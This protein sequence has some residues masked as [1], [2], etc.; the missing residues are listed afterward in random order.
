MKKVLLVIDMQNI[1]VGENHTPMFKYDNSTLIKNV[2]TVISQHDPKNVYYILNIMK[3]NLISKL[4]PF[5]AFEGSYEV[6]LVS[7]L[8][9]VNNNKFKKYKGN[10]FSNKELGQAL[11][12][13]NVMEIEIVGVDG[14][15]CVARTAFGALKEGFNVILNTNA[16]G[17]TF[18]KRAKKLNGKLKS[19]NVIFK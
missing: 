11:R 18:V 19:Q 2:N 17:T 9:V 4:A 13:A 8:S 14:G 5:K 6:E 3:Y 1:C 12:N 16:I 15:G 10:A 7:N